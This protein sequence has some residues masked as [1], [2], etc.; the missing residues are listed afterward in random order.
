M[1]TPE[2]YS[3]FPFILRRLRLWLLWLPASVSFVQC[4]FRSVPVP[5][6]RCRQG[7]RCACGLWEDGCMYKCRCPQMPITGSCPASKARRGIRKSPCFSYLPSNCP[8]HDLSILKFL[9]IKVFAPLYCVRW[10]A[11]IFAFSSYLDSFMYCT[12]P[13]R[14]KRFFVRLLCKSSDCGIIT[15]QREGRRRILLGGELRFPRPAAQ[16]NSVLC[17][18]AWPRW[19]FKILFPNA[20]GVRNAEAL[21]GWYMRRCGLAYSRGFQSLGKRSCGRGMEKR[22]RRIRRVCFP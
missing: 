10:F 7:K 6:W 1:H 22:A 21:R 5:D 18:L 13:L 14:T 4:A 3:F 12:S 17:G 16:R 20:V 15:A 19:A 9:Q 8:N 11:H 2:C